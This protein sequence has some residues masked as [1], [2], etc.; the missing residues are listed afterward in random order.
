MAL[1][2]IDSQNH[3]VSTIVSTLL[4]VIQ[5]TQ[6]SQ[7][8]SVDWSIM[9]CDSLLLALLKIYKCFATKE[10][11]APSIDTFE[12]LI[13]FGVSDNSTNIIISQVENSLFH[14]DVRIKPLKVAISYMLDEL[15]CNIQQHAQVSTGYIFADYN[16]STDSIDICLA[17]CGVTIYGSYVQSGKYLDVIGNSDAEALNIAKDGYST[18]NRPDAENRGYG[19]SSNVKMITEGLDGTFAILSG[20]ALMINLNGTMQ[21]ASLPEDIEWQGTCVVIR[22]PI[23]PDRTFNLY[24]YIS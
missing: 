10:I 22:I 5:Q 16:K 3:Q 17:D 13:E 19:I 9:N 2:R 21:V 24:D 18:K 12:D 6:T 8:K 1:I 7:D 4:N 15:I 11:N 14:K 23:D 20:N